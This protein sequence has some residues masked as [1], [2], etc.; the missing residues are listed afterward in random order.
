M[1]E[2]WRQAALQRDNQCRIFAN[3][4]LVNVLRAEVSLA[5]PRRD[6]YR[7]FCIATNGIGWGWP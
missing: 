3:Y 7:F 2:S 1:N 4:A 6:R 5:D